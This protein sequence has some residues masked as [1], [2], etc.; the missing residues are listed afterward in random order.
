M[1]VHQFPQRVHDMARLY[2]VA[3]RN[4]LEVVDTAAVL[5]SQAHAESDDA[6][7]RKA[8]DEAYEALS[9]A[10]C[11]LDYLSQPPTN[12]TDDEGA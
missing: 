3:T 10:A 12:I 4:T 6:E 9:W 5:V 2:R 8:L 11:Q 7:V 1:T